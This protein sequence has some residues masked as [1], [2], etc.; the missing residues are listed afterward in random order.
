L[1]LFQSEVEED[2]GVGVF[3][4]RVAG[5]KE[6]A[7]VAGGDGA[8]QGVG[9]GVEQDVAVGVAGEAFGW[10]SVSPPMRSGT[11]GLNACESQ[12]NPMRVSMFTVP[13]LD[14]KL[15]IFLRQRAEKPRPVG[16][17]RSGASLKR[18]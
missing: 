7:D 14:L 13:I 2:G 1:Q 9:D 3:P 18:G 10:S 6:A 16:T 5:G 15:C 17:L 4:A 12:P 11:P 8:E